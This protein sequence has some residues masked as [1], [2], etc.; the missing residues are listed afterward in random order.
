MPFHFCSD[1]LF[2]ILAALPFIGLFF[3][4]IHTWLHNRLNHKCHKEGCE[5][6]HLDH[7]A[8]V[9]DQKEPWDLI[10]Q[11]DIEA[12]FGGLLIDDLVHDSDFFKA[13]PNEEELTWYV[14]DNTWVKA[15]YKGRKFV[16]VIDV[17][18]YAWYEEL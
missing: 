17:T 8:R 16:H 14:I 15:T 3:R 12:R 4:R 5:A 1:E 18:L 6:Q 2:A 11:E 10:S 7:Y 13:P 9:E